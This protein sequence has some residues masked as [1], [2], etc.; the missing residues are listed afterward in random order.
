MVDTQLAQGGS[1]LLFEVFPLAKHNRF[2]AL[3]VEV[4]QQLRERR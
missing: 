2:L 4:L 1:N 3:A